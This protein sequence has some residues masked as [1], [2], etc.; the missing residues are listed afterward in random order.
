MSPS[1]VADLLKK[2]PSYAEE[3]SAPMSLPAAVAVL[4]RMEPETIAPVVREMGPARI[5]AR[6]ARLGEATVIRVVL[7]LRS[8]G[9]DTD[10]IV[11][12]LPPE[13]GTAVA[14]ALVRSAQGAKPDVG[15]LDHRR[16]D[17][18]GS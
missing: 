15:D 2:Y 11:K 8:G 6:L 5:A 1:L 18:P 16:G 17:I 13:L 7:D 4:R 12:R 14:A 10:R 9:S 3:I